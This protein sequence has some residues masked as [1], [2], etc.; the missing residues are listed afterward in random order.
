MRLTKVLFDKI[1]EIPRHYR[2]VRYGPKKWRDYQARDYEPPYWYKWTG[3]SPYTPEEQNKI[4]LGESIGWYANN[5]DKLKVVDPNEWLYRVGDKVQVLTGKDKGK[6]GY[7]SKV[8]PEGNVI[9]VAGR[10]CSYE[11]RD[12]IG[13]ERKEKPLQHHEVSLLDPKDEKPVDVEFKVSSEGEKVRISKRSGHVI[14]WPPEYLPDGSMKRDYVCGEK[15]TDAEEAKKMT[16][17]PSLDSWEEELVN[18]Y[19]VQDHPRKKTYWY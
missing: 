8:F 7:V 10:N 19:N 3:E 6:Y 5:V 16:Y 4:K 17:T 13:C 2:F 11:T 14:Y 15:D 1:S 9:I 12:N 18:H